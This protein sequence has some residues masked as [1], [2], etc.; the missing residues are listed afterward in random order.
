MIVEAR[1]FCQ[2]PFVLAS[3]ARRATS[4][5]RR[6]GLP[7]K[8]YPTEFTKTSLDERQDLYRRICEEIWSSG[9][10]DRELT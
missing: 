10:F 1:D 8:S 6:S 3:S 2:H 7:F 5:I 4:S 9:R